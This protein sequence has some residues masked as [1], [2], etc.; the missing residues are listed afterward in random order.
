MN[1]FLWVGRHDLHGFAEERDNTMIPPIAT[2]E[3]TSVLR[4]RVLLQQARNEES[5]LIISVL[6]PEE[7][8]STMQLESFPSQLISANF[9]SSPSVR[10][11][12]AG[13]TT[14]HDFP[15][16]CCKRCLLPLE[17]RYSYFPTFFSFIVL[18]TK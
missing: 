14:G 11:V 17:P 5:I 18:I 16:L 12:G 2:G 7:N 4:L 6:P 3:V 13:R 8:A 9:R 1:I 15:M 10:D